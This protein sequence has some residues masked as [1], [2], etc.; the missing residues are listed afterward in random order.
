MKIFWCRFTTL[1]LFITM[2]AIQRSGAQCP[3]ADFTIASPVCAGSALNI[4]NSSSN[5]TTYK[6][7][8]APGYFSQPATRVSDTAL[9]LSYPGDITTMVENDTVITFI[10]G[11]GDGKLYR[12]IYGNGPDQPFTSLENLGNLGGMVYQPSDVTFFRQNSEWYGFV[13]DY[14]SNTLVRF[15]LGSSLR[16]TPDSVVLLLNNTVSNMNSPWSIKIAVDESG[17]IHGLVANFLTGT[18]THLDFGNSILNT[19]LAASPV[20]VSGTTYVLDLDIAHECGN[21]YAFIAGYS[22]TNIIL[23]DFGNSLSNTPAFSTIISN[24]SPSDICIV[25]DSTHWKILYTNYNSHEVMKYDLGAYLTGS[26]PSYLGSDYFGGSNPKGITSVRKGA[27][28]F[29]SVFYTG[30]MALS[31]FRYSNPAMV[32]TYV[33][34]AHTPVGI[35]FGGGG[36]FP[37]TLTAYDNAGNSSTKTISV[38]IVAGPISGFASTAHCLGNTT[39]FTDTSTITTGNINSWSWDFGDGITSTLQ[40]P[41]HQFDSAN[42]YHVVLVTVSNAGCSDTVNSVINI[43][44]KPVAAFSA[45]NSVCSTT[46][47]QFTDQSTVASGTVTQWNWNFG[48]GNTSSSQD[49]VYSFP[50]GGNIP[51]TLQV[52]TAAGCSSDSTMMFL[53]Y[54]RPTAD[55]RAD[56]TCINENVQFSDLTTLSGSS[57]SSYLWDYGDGNTDTLSN[58]AHMYPA[59]VAGYN[60]RLI[61]T[62]QNGCSDTALQNIKINNIPTVNFSYQPAVVCEKNEVSF[63]DLSIVSGDTITNWEWDFG[64]GTLDS[65]SDPKHKFAT[66]GLYQVKLIAYAPSRCPG[67]A[68][69]QFINVI[70][71]P[72]A[73]FSASTTCLGLSTDFVN[74]S[75]AANG[76]SI[77]SVNWKFTPTDSSSIFSPNFLFP[78]ST[79]YPVYLT[80]ISP[81]GCTSTDSLAVIVHEQPVANFSHSNACS[82]TPAHFT[83]QSTCDS[84][85][86]ISQYEWNFGDFASGALNFS[87]L[88]N[89]SHIFSA[90]SSYN[91]SL[92]VTTNFGCKDT[93]FTTITVNQSPPANFT[94]SPTCYGSLMEFFNP[95]SPMDSLYHWNFGDNQY[96]QLREPAHF[97]AFPGTYT[98]SLNVTSPSGCVATATKQVTVSPIPIADFI[99]TPAC[100]NTDYVFQNTSSI[101]SGSIVTWKWNISGLAAP[102]SIKYPSYTFSDTGSYSVGLTVTS[103]IGCT[104]SVTKTIGVHKLPVANFSSNPQF[105]NP[106][107]DIQLIDYSTGGSDFLWDFGDNTGT[108]GMHEPSHTYLDTGMFTITQYVTSSFGC[109]DTLSKFIYVIKP[110]L[111]IAVTGDSSYFDGNYFHIVGRIAN[112]GTRNISSLKMEAELEDGSTISEDYLQLIP[113]GQSGLQTYAFHASF[114]LSSQNS[115]N[116]YCIRALRPNGE[117]DDVPSNNERCFNLTHQ[118][119]GLEVFPNPSFEAFTLRI[120]PP[121]IDYLTVDLYNPE[122]KK[123]GTLYDGLTLKNMK[124]LQYDMS[125]LEEGT[126]RLYITYG[127]TNYS[128]PVIHFKLK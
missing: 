16:N 14:G 32:N 82:G 94:Y 43:T 80:V 106:P 121:F 29:V 54:D 102:D 81:E 88:Q 101:A 91:S 128:R 103:D 90:T 60:V 98:V 108:S 100:V 39:N 74:L 119:A 116:Y 27:N 15:H 42:S 104:K 46:Q 37:V 33:D 25:N 56:N 113:I 73:S 84:T 109:K 36:T 75:T 19:P 99:A 35:F 123:I 5:A 9:A 2:N 96:N 112:L 34:S 111:D 10:S 67:T 95:G 44:P 55:F 3:V 57:I 47:L 8:F 76:S 11:K 65:V 17:M 38:T 72:V 6:W 83:S 97:Y 125:S 115:F 21:W 20:P 31:V 117:N 13:T 18:I 127:Q 107:L 79:T 41:S 93:A 59:I 26:S 40:N 70:E 126:Y 120:I 51:V 66:A 114:L 89:P 63:T 64:D 58:P 62:A 24:G 22:S 30:N 68:F 28:S 4:T 7:D 50:Y 77:S 53:V 85:S 78:S 71:S 23:A 45:P 118:L 87:S 52:T 92:I 122:G 61:V 1:I 105:G 49:P 12:A 110:I 86:T 124:D 48:T 69:Q